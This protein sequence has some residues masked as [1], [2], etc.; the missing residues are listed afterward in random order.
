MSNPLPQPTYHP[1]ISAFMRWVENQSVKGTLGP[2]PAVN[3][4]FMPLPRLETYLKDGNRTRALLQALFPYRQPPIEPEEV[5]RNCI[6]VFSILLLIGKGEFIQ[7]FVQ[8]GQLWDSKLPFSSAQHF[9]PTA[10]G[11]AFFDLFYQKQWHFCAYTFDRSVIEAH[12][13]K[14]RI[15]P[16]VFKEQLPGGGSA[17]TYKIRLHP[18]YDYLTPPTDIRRVCL[19]LTL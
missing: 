3:H 5:W 7:H 12:L 4:P 17:L 8:H 14:Q 11:G 6:R 1:D 13:E 2:V 18:A 10:S 16:I 9:P 19:A 15:L